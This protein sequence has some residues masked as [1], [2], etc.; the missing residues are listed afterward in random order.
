MR[1]YPQVTISA[2]MAAL[3][4]NGRLLD[5]AQ[6]GFVGDG[7]WAVLGPDGE[8]LAMYEVRDGIEVK[9]SVVLA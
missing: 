1:D 9:P 5:R 8:L 2:E 6:C 3:V 7:P 4:A